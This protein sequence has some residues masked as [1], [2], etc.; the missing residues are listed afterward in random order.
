V[1]E[2][3]TP[4]SDQVRSAVRIATAHEED[5]VV[6]YDDGAGGNPVRQAHGRPRV[7]SGPATSRASRTALPRSSHARAGVPPIVPG[8]LPEEIAELPPLD[9]ARHRDLDVTHA[10]AAPRQQA[11]R[12]VELRAPEESEIH[13]VSDD[14][15]ARHLLPADEIAGLPTLDLLAN[16]GSASLTT[17]LSRRRSGRCRGR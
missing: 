17:F 14:V 3:A 8:R 11:R 2:H 4:R 16:A 9:V 7:R 5:P 12:I 15:E 13:P 1:L 6:A 10:L